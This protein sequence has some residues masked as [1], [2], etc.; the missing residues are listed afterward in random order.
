MLPCCQRHLHYSLSNAATWFVLEL[1]IILVYMSF[2]NSSFLF[3]MLIGYRPF[4][5]FYYCP[6][7]FFK[8]GIPHPTI[9]TLRI[10]YCC[11]RAKSPSC[12]N[13][14]AKIGF[15]I[16]EPDDSLN[17]WGTHGIT[18]CLTRKCLPSFPVLCFD[19]IWL[20]KIP[21]SPWS[22]ETRYMSVLCTYGRISIWVE[23]FWLQSQSSNL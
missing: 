1:F 6:V 21:F 4:G 5:P 22:R 8:G 23:Y 19:L 11:C 15:N 10:L 17:L 12:S 18:N 13:F 14:L 20:Q 3:C 7:T 9:C 2:W 16:A